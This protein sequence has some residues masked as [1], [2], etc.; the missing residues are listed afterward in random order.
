MRVRTFLS[1]STFVLCLWIS[2]ALSPAS[3]WSEE[4][5]GAAEKAHAKSESAK[6]DGGAAHGGD[7]GHAPQGVPLDPRK[8]LAMW[9]VVVFLIFLFVL[10]KFAWGP[11]IA[12]LDER[13]GRI[14]QNIAEAEEAH[15]KAVK[16]LAQHAE[17]LNLVQDEVR[18]IVA[19]ARR[20]AEH[21]KN[22]ILAEAQREAEATKQRAILEIE[23]SRDAAIKELFDFVSS[24]VIGA[25][26]HVLGRALS[27]DDQKRLVQEAL[28]Q[29]GSKT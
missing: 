29:I 24:N 23:R 15:H 4:E 22:E 12:G 3:A 18:E 20:D 28:V 16:L 8:D 25:T 7:A 6:S 26:E 21:T 2:M 9:S 19:E 14:R 17:K 11:L 13:E 5:H 1:I 10:R 27:E